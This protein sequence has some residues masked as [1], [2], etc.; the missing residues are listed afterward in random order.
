MVE[1]GWLWIL[2]RDKNR[3]GLIA[4]G[5]TKHQRAE[6]VRS[7]T[8]KTTAKVLSLTQRSLAISGCSVNRSKALRST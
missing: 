4:I 5:I 8:P 1:V 3:D 7:L 2:N 6:V